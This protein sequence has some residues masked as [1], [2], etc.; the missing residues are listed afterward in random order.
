MILNGSVNCTAKKNSENFRKIN[1]LAYVNI[2]C[3]SEGYSIYI[4][5][6]LAPIKKVNVMA[7]PSFDSEIIQAFQKQDKLLQNI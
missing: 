6:F 5:K 3:I 2:I 7:K 1:F 4:T